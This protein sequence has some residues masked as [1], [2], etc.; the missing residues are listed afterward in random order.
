VPEGIEEREWEFL[1]ALERRRYSADTI[2]RGQSTGLRLM[3][4]LHGGR[5]RLG[6]PTRGE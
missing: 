3:R 4:G 1:Q 5:P 2:A 6:C